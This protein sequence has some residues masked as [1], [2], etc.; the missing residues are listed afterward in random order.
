MCGSGMSVFLPLWPIFM[1]ENSGWDFTILPS[2][3]SVDSVGNVITAPLP[4]FVYSNLLQNVSRPFINPTHLT[5]RGYFM[6]VV[7]ANIALYIKPH[8][9][10]YAYVP[11][12]LLSWLKQYTKHLYWKHYL[13]QN[14]K[15][16][17]WKRVNNLVPGVYRVVWNLVQLFGDNSTLVLLTRVFLSRKSSLDSIPHGKH[18]RRYYLGGGRS[19]EW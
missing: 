16:A 5:W 9:L 2:V 18:H 3:S 15:L 19:G 14:N 7:R 17:G 4:W 12:S 1:N 10:S 6:Y 11:S 8:I 13:V